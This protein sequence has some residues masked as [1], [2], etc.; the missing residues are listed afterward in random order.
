MA[1]LAWVRLTWVAFEC[2]LLRDPHDVEDG[3]VDA[4]PRERIDHQLKR[5]QVL[6]HL[7][8]CFLAE[9]VR[10]HA[11]LELFEALDDVDALKLPP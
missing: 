1:Y 11:L 2:G 3:L 5:V 7:I 10:L 4:Q 8:D 6:H 9:E